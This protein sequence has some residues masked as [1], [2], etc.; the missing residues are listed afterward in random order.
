MPLAE[1]TRVDSLLARIGP[2]MERAR[3]AEASRAA[4]I[5]LRHYWLAPSG[6]SVAAESLPPDAPLDA[7]TA[8]AAQEIRGHIARMQQRFMNHDL[9]GARREYITATNEL[10]LLRRFDRDHRRTADLQRELSLGVRDLLV[11]CY[12]MRADSALSPGVRCESFLA[13]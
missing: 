5:P 3:R 2:E 6:D 9:A 13:R 11:M 4:R 7:R 12:R 1:L 10:A 8:V